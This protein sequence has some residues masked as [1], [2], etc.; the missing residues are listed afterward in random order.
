MHIYIY[1]YIYVYIEYIN[2][3]ILIFD[4]IDRF[5]ISVWMISPINLVTGTPYELI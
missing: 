4:S 3:C 5:V 2:I 1:I